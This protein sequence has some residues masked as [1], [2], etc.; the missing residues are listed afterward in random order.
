MHKL[1]SSAA[2]RPIGISGPVRP[3]A[4]ISCF[5]T[6]TVALLGLAADVLADSPRAEILTASLG[7][8][9]ANQDP[10]EQDPVDNDSIDE[11]V[12]L[13][14]RT[15]DEALVERILR[16]FELHQALE[17]K[18]DWRLKA[19]EELE[20][21]S[22]FRLGY[23]FGGEERGPVYRGTERLPLDLVVPAVVI[24]MDF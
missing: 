1:S 2:S 7:T 10:M 17:A 24:S 9:T 14:R 21:R 19:A 23:D 11:I 15:I 22:P 4:F 6:A 12:V 16:D 5:L 20:R 8:M 18:P 3:P 13:G